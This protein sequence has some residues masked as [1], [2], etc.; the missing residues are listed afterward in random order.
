MLKGIAEHLHPL[1][2][3]ILFHLESCSPCFAEF[4]SFKIEA[5]DRRRRRWIIGALAIATCLLVCIVFWKAR[6][7]GHQ[8]LEAQQSAQPSAEA[9]G[10]TREIDLSRYEATRG[11]G[12][13]AVQLGA[14]S[15]P[16]AIVHLKLVLPLLSPPGHYKVAVSTD[17]G[18]DK[19][20]ANSEGTV[21]GSKMLSVT[22][23]LRKAPR[24][25]Y[26]LST[27]RDEDSENYYCPVNL[28]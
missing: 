18:G 19:T 23:D 9:G 7:L 8:S 4:R 20:I 27:K 6:S 5:Q 22:L 11:V 16:R 25:A 2:R 15:L 13:T 3:E 24:G 21:A 1:N 10:V 17:R 12:D 28:Q 14:V 26:F